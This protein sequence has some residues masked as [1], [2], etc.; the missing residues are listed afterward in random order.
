MFRGT[1]VTRARYSGFLRNVAIAMGNRG[2]PQFRA[3]LVKLAASEDP[4]VAECAR[5][6]L[7]RCRQSCTNREITLEPRHE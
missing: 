4:A 3:P 2:L 1:P 6:A 5:W 7:D